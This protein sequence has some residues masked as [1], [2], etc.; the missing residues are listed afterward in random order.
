M[1]S[2]PITC[3]DCGG[4]GHVSCDSTNTRRHAERKQ[5]HG[6]WKKTSSTESSS[7]DSASVVNAQHDRRNPKRQ[8]RPYRDGEGRSRTGHRVYR[9]EGDYTPH[10]YHNGQDSDHNNQKQTRIGGQN[11]RQ[12]YVT[13]QSP[14]PHFDSS[15]S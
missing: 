9:R 8:Q 12:G 2:I 4:R 3:Y 5:R 11:I 7:N 1:F 10:G 13:G 14:C 6:H 15:A